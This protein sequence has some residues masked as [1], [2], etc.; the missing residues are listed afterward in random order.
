MKTQMKSFLLPHLEIHQNEIF[1]ALGWKGGTR[2]QVQQCIDSVIKKNDGD[3]RFFFNHQPAILSD[4]GI[5]TVRRVY[6]R[7]G[8][9]D[10]ISLSQ[11][12]SAPFVDYFKESEAS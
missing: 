5:L 10:W 7:T 11:E 9:I 2:H 8:K 12:A 6:S 3:I 4:N 1:N